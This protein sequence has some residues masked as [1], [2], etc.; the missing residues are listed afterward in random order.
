MFLIE[1]ESYFYIILTTIIVA[2]TKDT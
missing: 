1:P 2:M